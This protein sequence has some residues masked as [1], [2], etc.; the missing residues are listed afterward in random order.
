MSFEINQ[1]FVDAFGQAIDR[2]VQQGGS[3]LRNTVDVDPSVVGRTKFYDQFGVVTAQAPVSRHADTPLMSTPHDKRVLDL[4]EREVSELVDDFDMVKT[5]NDPTNSYVQ[6]FG[7]ALGRSIDEEIIRAARAT[8]VTGLDRGGTESGTAAGQTVS[9]AGGLTVA[10]LNEARTILRANEALRDGEMVTCVT[11][12]AGIQ[13]LLDQATVQSIDTNGIRAL[14][15]GEVNTYMGFQ[16]V[17][18]ELI[19][20]IGTATA[21]T[22]VYPRSAIKLG[23]GKDIRH[24]IAEDPGKRFS[25]RIYS[26]ASFGATRMQAEKVVTIN[27]DE[28]P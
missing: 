18:T 2:V 26:C 24:R 20:G 11:S 8:A 25:T 16:F 12:A 14:V 10:K 23:L 7:D 19:E 3:R 1:W 28:G 22:L 27:V 5:L 21:R 15:N 4:I 6:N 17:Q 13:D 9:T